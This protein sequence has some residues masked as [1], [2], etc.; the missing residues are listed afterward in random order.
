VANSAGS[1]L[2]VVN[3]TAASDSTLALRS[4]GTD[5]WRISREA[6]THR[7]LVSDAPSGQTALII[8]PGSAGRR[9]RMDFRSDI[10]GPPTGT[11]ISQASLAVNLAKAGPKHLLLAVG[12]NGSPRFTVDAEGDTSIAGTLTVQGAIAGT[13]SGLTGS[14]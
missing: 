4:G 13:G 1:A 14:P 8:D 9:I 2:L 10:E 6:A 12:N 3:G 11:T 5:Q 7:L